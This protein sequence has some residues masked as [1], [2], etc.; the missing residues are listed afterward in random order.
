MK[1]WIVP[2]YFEVQADTEEEAWR[3]VNEIEFK[4]Q[5]TPVGVVPG[6]IGEPLPR[7]EEDGH[8]D[9]A[10]SGLRWSELDQ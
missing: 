5:N 10:N 6:M 1:R 3:K 2:L 4:T 8:A 9:A 7:E